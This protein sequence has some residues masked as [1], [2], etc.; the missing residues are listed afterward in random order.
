MN[1]EEAG[2]LQLGQFNVR[3]LQN[4]KPI[5]SQTMPISFRKPLLVST[6][7]SDS[8]RADSYDTN[9]GLYSSLVVGEANL[10]IMNQRK[11]FRLLAMKVEA[12]RHWM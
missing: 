9:D 11:E 7:E 12:R 6:Y 3:T 1:A 4:S 5:P 8:A 10:R 2:Y